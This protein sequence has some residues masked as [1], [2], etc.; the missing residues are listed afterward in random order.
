MRL[1]LCVLTGVGTIAIGVLLVQGQVAPLPA[2]LD[3]GLG[4]LTLWLLPGGSRGAAWLFILWWAL[5]L[6]LIGQATSGGAP[7][8]PERWRTAAL[9]VVLYVTGAW[10]AFRSTGLR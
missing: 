4:I 6:V 5:C 8:S 10:T 2:T 9:G 7:L 1:A 3:I